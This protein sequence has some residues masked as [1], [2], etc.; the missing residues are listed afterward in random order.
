MARDEK[1]L[2]RAFYEIN[3]FRAVLAGIEDHAFGRVSPAEYIERRRECL[4]QALED[5]AHYIHATVQFEPLFDLTDDQKA[6][7]VKNLQV[8]LDGNL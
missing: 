6:L 5:A 8:L 1:N 3:R 2:Q 4:S 7:I